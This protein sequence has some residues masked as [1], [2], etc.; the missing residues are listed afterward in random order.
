[1]LDSPITSITF[2]TSAREPGSVAFKTAPFFQKDQHTGVLTVA[3]PT[4]PR[5]TKRVHWVVVLGENT[6]SGKPA[7]Q[8]VCLSTNMARRGSANVESAKPGATVEFDVKLI[9]PGM[10]HTAYV[11]TGE[12]AADLCD[13][14]DILAQMDAARM[15][16]SAMIGVGTWAVAQAQYHEAIKHIAAEYKPELER[17]WEIANGSE[18]LSACGAR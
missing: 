16:V 7:R 12:T 13:D 8:L 3:L 18:V 10:V 4:G 5:A 14:A 9:E 11:W 2:A 1:M 15:K 6:F 17:L